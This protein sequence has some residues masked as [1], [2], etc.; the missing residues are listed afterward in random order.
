MNDIDRVAAIMAARYVNI[1]HRALVEDWDDDPSWAIEEAARMIHEE[2]P[3][4]NFMAEFYKKERD[5]QEIIQGFT[6]EMMKD[7][8]KMFAP[9]ETA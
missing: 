8:A 6:P 9:K 4:H 5:Y 7:A 2:F 1:S 3:S